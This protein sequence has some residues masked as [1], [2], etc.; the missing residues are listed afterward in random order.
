MDDE[1]A[2]WLLKPMLTRLFKDAKLK[3]ERVSSRGERYSIHSEATIEFGR[4]HNYPW[5]G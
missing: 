3:Y 5:Q 2:L 4:W 1:E